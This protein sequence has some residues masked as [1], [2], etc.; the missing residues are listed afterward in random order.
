MLKYILVLSLSLCSCSLKTLTKQAFHTGNVNECLWVKRDITING[1]S[2]SSKLFYCC[3]NR[4]EKKYYP[5]CVENFFVFGGE[6]K[7]WDQ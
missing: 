4:K 5:V 2:S 1:V 6:E 3:P 7:V